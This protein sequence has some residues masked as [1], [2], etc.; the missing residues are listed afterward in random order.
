MKYVKNVDFFIFYKQQKYARE[1]NS[2]IYPKTDLSVLLK[3][4]KNAPYLKNI[5][6]LFK[7]KH[8]Q[9]FYKI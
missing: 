7:T 4:R 1:I 9:L 5:G 8:Y 3:R 2:S 6:I